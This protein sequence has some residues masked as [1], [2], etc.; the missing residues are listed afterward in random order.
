MQTIRGEANELNSLYLVCSIESSKVMARKTLSL[1]GLIPILSGEVDY[2]F[3]G[4]KKRGPIGWVPL[5]RT[6]EA[7]DIKPWLVCSQSDFSGLVA[8][9]EGCDLLEW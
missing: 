4:V 6:A 9:R 5:H 7:N 2:V 3:I 8:H 1:S